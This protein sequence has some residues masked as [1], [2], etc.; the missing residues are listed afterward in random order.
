MGSTLLSE[1]LQIT[2]FVPTPTKEDAIS[3]PLELSTSLRM[4]IDYAIRPLSVRDIIPAPLAELQRALYKHCNLTEN[5]SVN[6]ERGSQSKR[7][8]EAEWIS[9]F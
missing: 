7:M 2:S 5:K 1:L 6:I 3:Q 9:K 8:S 4:H